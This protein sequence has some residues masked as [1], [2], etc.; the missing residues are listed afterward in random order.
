M[1]QTA[2]Y[3]AT[4]D[5]TFLTGTRTERPPFETG[6]PT[7]PYQ[8]YGSK[9]TLTGA[10]S[11]TTA[12]TSS[13]G[14]TTTGANFTTTASPTPTNTQPCNNHVE[15]CTR[16]YSNITNVGCHN[17]PFV[18]PGNSGSNQAVDVLTQL[19]DGIRFLQAQIQWPPNSSTPHFCHTSCDLLDAGPIYNWLGRVAGWVDAH[20]YDVV[21]IL[22]GNG[23]YSDPSLYVPFIERS[24]ITKYVY[25]APYLPMALNDWPTLE[26]MIIRGK[27]VVMFL[28]Y[29]ANQ[30]KYPWLLD[31][32]SQ[33]WETPFD[34]QDRAFPCTVQRPPD[35]SKKAAMDR[36]YLMNHNLNVQ[37]DVFGVQLLVPAVSLLNETNGFNGT[38]S[39]GLAANN[40]RSDWGRAPNVINVDYYN[41]G[42]PKPCSVFA[43]AAAVNNVTYDYSE[44]C[45]EPSAASHSTRAPTLWVMFATFA[46]VAFWC[47]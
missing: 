43:A 17:S 40:C 13:S 8:S 26:D 10:S 35:L 6:P 5:L 3:T 45:G 36:M 41:Y 37:F 22:L 15:F 29:Q 46:V 44:P 34:P 12:V 38:G 39:A 27:R 7:G 23:N 11:R 32:F 33:M 20:P 18:V 31:E 1:S 25:S 14:T 42:S 9:I 30:T 2:S 16:R 28:D 47:H 24:G 21:T 4:S 19:N